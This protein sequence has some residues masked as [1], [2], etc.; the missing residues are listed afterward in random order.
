M[1]IFGNFLIGICKTGFEDVYN[2]FYIRIFVQVFCC[3]LSK[4]TNEWNGFHIWAKK[5][6]WL[7]KSSSKKSNW[8]KSNIYQ[9][10]YR[11]LL[12]QLV[13]SL[14][15]FHLKRKLT[16]SHRICIDTQ[17]VHVFHFAFAYIDRKIFATQ[18]S[19]YKCV[20]CTEFPLCVKSNRIEVVR[21]KNPYNMDAKR[22][23]SHG[24][25]GKVF[26]CVAVKVAVVLSFH[27]SWNKGHIILIEVKANTFSTA[28]CFSAPKFHTAIN[29]F[30]WRSMSQPIKLWPK[31]KFVDK[32]GISVTFHFSSIIRN[33]SDARWSARYK[34]TGMATNCWFIL[35]KIH[36]TNAVR[37]ST[38]SVVT[39]LRGRTREKLTHKKW[40]PIFILRDGMNSSSRKKES[41]NL[42]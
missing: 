4:Q 42:Q 25:K 9:T 13:C 6:R 5:I 38:G 41:K 21:V 34:S 30:C 7:K 28:F 3:G 35:F 32:N 24:E 23:C 15:Y 12:S 8:N 18:T 1:K 40:G 27:F 26:F 29:H 22:R 2:S 19:D 17:S 14:L 33:S 20:W 11:K 16:I 31:T 36:V 10:S 37:F 39:H